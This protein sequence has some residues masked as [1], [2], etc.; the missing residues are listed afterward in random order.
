MKTIFCS[1]LL[2][3]FDGELHEGAHRTIGKFMLSARVHFSQLLKVILLWC[4]FVPLVYAGAADYVYTTSI[5]QGE[6]E[7]GIKLG[8][9]APV[10][11]LGQQVAGIGLGYGVTDHWFTEL[12]LKREHTGGQRAILAEWENKWLFTEAGQYLLDLGMLAELELPLSGAAPWELRVGPLLQAEIGK[13]QLNGNLLFVRAFG[14]KDETGVPFSTNL[15]SQWQIKYRWMP[16]L[17]FGMQGLGEFGKWDSWSQL[18]AQSHRMG[19]AIFGKIAL[20]QRQTIKYNAAWLVGVS[21]AAPAH[22]LRGKIEY[23]F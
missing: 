17:E 5:E 4:M 14:M 10:D 1:A 19:P 12:Y 23:E 21:A 18:A 3:P 20:G 13:F 8:S 9:A 11:G 22:T 16:S 6:R 2:L 15:A 7:L